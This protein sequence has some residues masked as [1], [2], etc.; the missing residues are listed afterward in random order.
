[1][2]SNGS[3]TSARN[4]QLLASVV[5]RKT[6]VILMTPD[7]E[8]TTFACSERTYTL[9]ANYAEAITEAGGIP[10]ILPYV[11]ENLSDLIALA[12]GILVTGAFPGVHITGERRAF[13]MALVDAGM[14]AGKPL[15]GICHG[16]QLIGEVLGGTLCSKLPSGDVSHLPQ[17][18]P[19][20]L[21]HAITLDT[22][23][24]FLSGLATDR[25]DQSFRVNSLHLHALVGEGRFH[26]IAR[27]PDGVIEAFE[28]L[29]PGFCMGVQWHP[30]YLLTSLDRHILAT[31][32]QHCA[33]S[34]FIQRRPTLSAHTSNVI[35]QRLEAQGLALPPPSVPPG[36]FVGAVITGDVI[37]V[38]GQVP[39]SD[40]AIVRTGHLGIDVSIEEG[41]ECAR[42]ALLN[43]LAQLEHLA[44]DLG[45][46]GSFVRLAGYV[47]A[48]AEFTEHGAVIE[49]ASALLRDLFPDRW[50]H[51]RIAIGVASLPRGVPVEIEL[52]AHLTGVN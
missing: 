43:A 8:E 25:E 26:V 37:T 41:R 11:R 13:E 39:L 36:S 44:G 21:A 20:A 6:P 18:V 29:T 15:L 23:T 32:V 33:D 16:M 47:G 2:T 46:I 48:S 52:T 19:D 35:R 12:D 14:K 51:A 5:A 30:E 50:A 1:M 24:R 9:R 42:F 3:T 17:A 49:G 40:G 28:G 38:S 27:S 22:S 45:R 4:T 31:F 10:L 34:T 7:L